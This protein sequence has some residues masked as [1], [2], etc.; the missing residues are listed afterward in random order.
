EELPEDHGLSG[1][2][3]LGCDPQWIE[4]CHPT[5]GGVVR[6]PR[7]PLQTFNEAR[8]TFR[9]R[10]SCM[11]KVRREQPGRGLPGC[12]ASC[13]PQ[14]ECRRTASGLILIIE[15]SHAEH[16]IIVTFQ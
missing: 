5:G 13:F 16:L 11:Q 7:P 2:L 1:S 15:M 14:L 9:Y 8:A 4:V 12:I 10:P 6:W 3:D